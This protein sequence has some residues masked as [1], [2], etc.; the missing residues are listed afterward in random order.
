M[1]KGLTV[2]RTADRQLGDCAAEK[3]KL[4]LSQRGSRGRMDGEVRCGAAVLRMRSQARR[5]V[6]HSQSRPASRRKTPRKGGRQERVQPARSIIFNHPR[7]FNSG[8]AKQQSSTTAFRLD[9]TVNYS[10]RFIVTLDCVEV[11]VWAALL[12]PK[13]WSDQ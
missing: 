1:E 2:D 5:R 7:N 11:S 8:S 13:L 4:Q 12:L 10:M 9:G 6:G 3:L